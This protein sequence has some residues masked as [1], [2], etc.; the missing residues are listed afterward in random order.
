MTCGTRAIYGTSDVQVQAGSGSD[1]AQFLEAGAVVQCDGVRERHREAG[2]SGQWN[3]GAGV[4][5]GGRQRRRLG[6]T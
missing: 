5:D 3:A 1:I 4:G 2:G 6:N